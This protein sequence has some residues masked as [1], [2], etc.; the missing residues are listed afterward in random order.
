MTIFT[1]LNIFSYLCWS[2][3]WSLWHKPRRSRIPLW[4]HRCCWIWR[5]RYS[6]YWGRQLCL[7]SGN[8]WLRSLEQYTVKKESQWGNNTRWK[9]KESKGEQYTVKTERIKR[10]TVHGQKRESKGE[11]YPVKTERIKRRTVHG[12]NRES[13][14][15]QYSVKTERIKRRTVHCEKRESMGEQYPVKTER[16]KRGTIHGEKESQW[17][18]KV[19]DSSRFIGKI[20]TK[21]NWL[22]SSS[23]LPPEMQN[24]LT[25]KV[26]AMSCIL[27][28]KMWK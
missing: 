5:G 3:C 24:K 4:W 27:F 1:S 21:R 2:P 6:R 23:H 8:T 7:Y 15:E 10:R 20:K 18:M 17:A 25:I 9:Q 14:G 16:I 13:M 11:Q 26:A 22:K 19:F 12:E 28:T